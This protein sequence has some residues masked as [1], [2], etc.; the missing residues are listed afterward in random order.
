MDSSAQ[1]LTQK[2]IAARKQHPAWLLLSSTRAP[3]V[4]ACLNSLFEYATDGIAE[5]DALQALSEMLAAY[6]SQDEYNIDPNNTRLHAGRELREWIKRG[7]VTERG[8][9]IYATDALATAIQFIESLDNRI[10]TSTASRLSVVQREIENLDLGLNPNPDSRINAIQN[11]IKHLEQELEDVKAGLVSVLPEEHAIERIREVYSLATGL[12]ADFRRVEDSWREADRQLR[13][14]IMSEKYH[15]GDIVD[16]LLDGQESLLSTPEGRVFDSFQQQLK[17][18]AE[19]D[20]MR[21]RLR[22]ILAHPAAL[23]ALNHPQLTDLKW[24]SLRLVRESQSVLQARARSEKDVKGFLKTGLAGEHHRVGQILSEIMNVALELDWQ[25][26]KVR[27]ADASLPPVGIA[28]GNLPVA[29]RLRFKSLENDEDKDL[30]LSVT[31]G[32]LNDIGDEFWEAFDGLDRDLA[33]Q[34]TLALLAKEGQPMTMVELAEAMPPV[35]DLET[36]ALWLGMAREANINICDDQRQ[37]IELTDE[38]QQ[39]WVFQVPKVALSA[40]ALDGI[41]W[42]F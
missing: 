33:I 9:R 39:H 25:S 27:R 30:D 23:K 15:R 21:L 35:H 29:E 5:E 22:S 37:Q 1:R 40:Q 8:Q 24:L 36:F 26:Q 28:L 32:D 31:E 34:K 2:Y 11:K 3:L 12:R 6:A 20:S 38:Q 17:Q 7:L 42:E 19:L 41:D 4:L 10:M 13:Q 18:S 16:R 14:S